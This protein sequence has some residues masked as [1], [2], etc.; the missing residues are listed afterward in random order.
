MCVSEAHFSGC[1]DGSH[2][3]SLQV[4]SLQVTTY[5]LSQLFVLII[6]MKHNYIKYELEN[7]ALYFRY[8]LSIS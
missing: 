5:R 7:N 4:C 8:F 1:T 3:P 2:A 6:T